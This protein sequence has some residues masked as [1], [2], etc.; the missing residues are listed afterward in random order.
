MKKLT[1][2]FLSL[3]LLLS[4]GCF[5]MAEGAQPMV[6]E[7]APMLEKPVQVTVTD[8]T[9]T[10]VIDAAMQI[11]DSENHVLDTWTTDGGVHT[12]FLKEGEY[13]V[14]TVAV[15]E[16]YVAGEAVRLT[17]APTE[18]EQGLYPAEV[19][20][21]HDHTEICSNPNHV[22]LELYTVDGNVAYCFNHLK[23][24]PENGVCR[25]KMVVA[26]PDLLWDY[27]NNKSDSIT[28][29]ELYQ[30]VRSVIYLSSEIQNK[31]DLPD[32]TVARFLT[33]MALKNYTDP[34]L[35][36]TFDENGNETIIRDENGRPVRD[37]N[38][39]YQFNPGGC[40]LG[41]MIAHARGEKHELPSNYID[42]YKY[43]TNP[44][45]YPTNQELFGYDLYIYMPVQME[46]NSLVDDGFQWLLSV[47][48]VEPQQVT[49]SVR[50]IPQT[51]QFGI[52]IKWK[53]TN[54]WMRLRPSTS[55]VSSKLHLYADGVE[56]TAEYRNVLS[57]VDNG[58]STYSVRFADLPKLNENGDEII[59][60]L[61]M[62]SVFLYVMDKTV[63][64]NGETL[65]CTRLGSIFNLPIR[66]LQPIRRGN[67][68]LEPIIG[69]SPVRP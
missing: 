57:V 16:G 61:K 19:V 29:E 1:S 7:N 63:V 8:E 64:W 59:Y 25:Y 34:K 32:E 42:A 35:F 58:N 13:S 60:T 5:V 39:N 26:T 49:V 17:V 24:N 47:N 46:N 11:I 14:E 20:Y 33:L 54:N 51:T 27:A 4:M 67:P 65:T 28:K 41:S 18:A 30:S 12:L 66:Q 62:D 21:D 44:E 56:V 22:G 40:V 50:T 48:R 31:F 3:A 2:L 37:E 23:R 15:P 36:Y 69:P 53:D 68:V 52:T 9:G 10:P 38:G 45:N 43:L 55:S 6:E